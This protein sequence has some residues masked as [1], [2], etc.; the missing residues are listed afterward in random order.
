MVAVVKLESRGIVAPE[1]WMQVPA[2]PLY[3]YRALENI[4]QEELY[5]ERE[6]NR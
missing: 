3:E 6:Q 1:F 2:G 5:I 4:Y